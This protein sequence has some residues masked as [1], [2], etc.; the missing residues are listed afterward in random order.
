VGE[1]AAHPPETE[2]ASYL[3]IDDLLRL[4]RPLTPEAPDELLFIV[5]HQV[6]E[7]WFKLVLHELGRVAA[8]LREGRVQAAVAPLRRVVTVEDIEERQL[9]VLETMG[10]EDFLSFRDPLAPASGFQS[11]QFRAIERVSASLWQAFCAAARTAGVAMPDGPGEGARDA[12]RG[13]L[14]HLYRD[15][16]GEP[17][18]AALHQ[19][20]ELLVDHDAAVARWRFRHAMMAAREIGSRPGTGGTPGVPYLRSTLDQRFYPELWEVRTAL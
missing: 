14:V 6:F 2:Y 13:A 15:H 20:A 12:R 7:L 19:V 18:R 10:P 11:K 5:I 8:A 4:Q 16:L 17:L 1:E 9:A 3:L